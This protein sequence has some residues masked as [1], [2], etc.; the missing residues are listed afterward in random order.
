[1]KFEQL[2]LHDAVLEKLEYDWASKVL[3]VT[4]RLSVNPPVFFSL[5]FERVK[6]IAIPQQEDL[7]PSSSINDL[8]KKDREFLINM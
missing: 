4:G 7:G 5:L 6:S 3:T 8:V 2:P 1:M